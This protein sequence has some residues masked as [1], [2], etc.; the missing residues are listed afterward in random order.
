MY[1]AGE[2]GTISENVMMS[3]LRSARV[4]QLGEAMD[5]IAFELAVDR[6]LALPELW[7]KMV[8]AASGFGA[9]RVGYHHLPPPGAPDAAILRIEN[10]GFADAMLE[11]YLHARMQGLAV[12]AEA[13]HRIGR[14]VYLSELEQSAF[15]TPDAQ[16][17]LARYRAVG[18]R[19]GMSLGAFGPHGRDGLFAFDLGDTERLDQV[20][21][22]QLRWA[23]QV[24]HLRYCE[25][26]LPTLGE[27][28]ALS[29]REAEVLSWVVRGKSNSAIAEILGISSHTVNS[30][31]R[32]VY[33]KLGV[34]DRVS[35]ALRAL[36]F[37]LI[38][39]DG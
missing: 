11:Q 24:M 29:G 38:K 32:R 39:I 31:L 27:V 12:L 15:L 37:G 19:N 30:H 36:C 17:H 18:V 33:L 13:V 14:P 20:S 10:E 21:L 22:G 16:E 4:A 28:P 8:S 23:A 3:E 26:L 5:A 2:F 25:L 7:K 35:A 34:F 6:V 9:I 1:D